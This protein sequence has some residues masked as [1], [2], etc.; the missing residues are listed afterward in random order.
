ML[1]RAVRAPGTDAGASGA[2]REARGDDRS[3]IAATE[4]GRERCATE[5]YYTS[6][7]LCVK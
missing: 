3:A 5:I 2:Q 6:S 1:K 7:T 4:T